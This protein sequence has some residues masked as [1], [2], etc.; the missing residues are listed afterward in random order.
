MLSNE[1][2]SAFVTAKKKANTSLPFA[3]EIINVCKTIPSL[4][5]YF[6]SINDIFLDGFTVELE[7]RYKLIDRIM[8]DST[9][10]WI[11]EF[12]SG[13]S[14]RAL[15]YKSKSLKFLEVDLAEVNKIKSIVYSKMELLGHSIPANISANVLDQNFWDDLIEILPI[16]AGVVIN[17]GLMRYLNFSEKIF[18]CNKI[19]RILEKTNGKWITCD[20]T[21]KSMLNSERV[22]SEINDKNHT[23][24]IVENNFSNAFDNIH[25][26]LNFFQSQ[27]FHVTHHRPSI[28]IDIDIDAYNVLN[29]DIIFDGLS[30][31][32]V[33]EMTLA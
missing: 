29:R 26:A 2:I 11:I 24:I 28:D 3:K 27:G 20:V 10:N 31:V 13:F 30:F 18:Y 16:S 14:G 22:K 15:Y 6:T 25:H 9:P 8:A 12:A 19:H 7:A 1:T 17:E 21:L 4:A 33:F 5:G 23:K 32:N